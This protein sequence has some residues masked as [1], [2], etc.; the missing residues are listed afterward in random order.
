MI[1]AYLD[2]RFVADIAS[3]P[4]LL[5]IFTCLVDSFVALS[6]SHHGKDKLYIA[7]HPDVARLRSV[8]SLLPIL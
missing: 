4:P 5:L 3:L 2:S 7:C 6:Q 8:L 1:D